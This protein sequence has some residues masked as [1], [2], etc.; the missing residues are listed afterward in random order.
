ME[1]ADPRQAVRQL[2]DSLHSP[3]LRGEKLTLYLDGELRRFLST[4]IKPTQEGMKEAC[5]RADR[6]IKDFGKH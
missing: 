1:D 5:Q 3:P 6:L 4:S 2:I